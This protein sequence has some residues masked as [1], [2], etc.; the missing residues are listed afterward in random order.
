[1]E[2][3]GNLLAEYEKLLRTTNLIAGYQEFIRLFRSLRI[4]L[5]NSMP[6]YKFQG[7]IAENALDYS[8]F[9]LSNEKLKEKGLK[10]AVVFVHQSF[11][12]EVWLSGYNRKYQCGYYALLK[13]RKIPFALTD[14]PERRDCIL[15]LP[16]EE[17]LLLSRGELQPEK[18]KKAVEELGSFGENL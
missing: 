8:Y 18:I 7:N 11:R 10:I 15:R 9:L 4:V 1:M 17:A 12:F 5:E 6:A 16:V 2:V 14:D 3:D 13:D